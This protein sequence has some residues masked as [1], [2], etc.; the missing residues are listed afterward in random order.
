MT[1]WLFVINKPKQ[2]CRKDNGQKT[3]TNDCLNN[4]LDH[5]C[6]L[7]FS[8][9]QWR[10]LAAMAQFL[11]DEL[12]LSLPNICLPI[13]ES[14]ASKW[15]YITLHKQGHCQDAQYE[16]HDCTQTKDASHFE[17]EA[18]HY[19]TS[20]KCCSTTSWDNR[21]TWVNVTKYNTIRISPAEGTG[22][23]SKIWYDNKAISRWQGKCDHKIR[24]NVM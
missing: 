18:L 15:S 22:K 10:L 5:I 14:D 17:V 24:V 20:C 1:K 9:Y 7:N 23:C 12:I 21:K 19:K 3:M 13:G 11:S 6:F 16:W 2:I 8:L 4:K